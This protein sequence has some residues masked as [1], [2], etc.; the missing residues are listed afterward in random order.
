MVARLQAVLTVVDKALYFP[1]FAQLVSLFQGSDDTLSPALSWMCG[2][3][4]D[5][6]RLPVTIPIETL[7]TR[8]AI[9]RDRKGSV[10]QLVQEIAATEGVVGFYRG[11]SSYF[12]MSL[13]PAVQD[14]IFIRLKQ[15]WLRRLGLDPA[16]SALS[17]RQGFV[18]GA[19]TRMIATM[20]TYPFLR[21]KLAAV[22]AK[23]GTDGGGGGGGGGR[24]TMATL[25]AIVK[26]EGVLSLY[27]GLSAELI[28]GVLFNATLMAVKESVDASSARMLGY[29]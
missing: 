27:R 23:R 4:A 2:Y 19:I 3:F 25:L 24:G 8:I 22:A 9:D 1:V 5:L 7:A 18:L 15:W 26:A 10:L 21:A 6:A 12:G 28:R 14:A 29:T 20:V 17:F 13:R 16:T 11:L